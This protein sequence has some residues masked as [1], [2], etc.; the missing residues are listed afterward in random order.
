MSTL[1]EVLTS[2]Q[3]TLAAV[4]ALPVSTDAD[5]PVFIAKYE[6]IKETVRALREAANDTATSD[7][8][9]R[10]FVVVFTAENM[11]P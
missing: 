8:A 1:A 10:A 9:F 7:G 2:A 3:A 4:Q 11:L 6:A 5:L